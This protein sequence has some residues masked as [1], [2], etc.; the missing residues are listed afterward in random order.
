MVD[1]IPLS[2]LPSAEGLTLVKS[3]MV[4]ELGTMVRRET[5]MDA[6]GRHYISHTP[7]PRHWSQRRNGLVVEDLAFG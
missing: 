2:I 3:E 4:R 6:D 7:L 1:A 5:R